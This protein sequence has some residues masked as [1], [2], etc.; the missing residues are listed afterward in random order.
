VVDV[1]AA[2]CNAQSGQAVA[3]CGEVL[4]VGGAACK[5]DEKRRLG[6]PPGMRSARYDAA[7]TDGDRG[8][9]PAIQPGDDHGG[10]EIP[11]EGKSPGSTTCRLL[12]SLHLTLE[13]HE[14][15]HQLLHAGTRRG[16]KLLGSGVIHRR[17]GAT[18][19]VGAPRQ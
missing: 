18:E 16:R 15:V 1:D 14:V 10:K 12:A 5:A 2:G 6:A 19:L 17:G 9:H 7:A 8:R 4:L 13:H 3:L 11:V